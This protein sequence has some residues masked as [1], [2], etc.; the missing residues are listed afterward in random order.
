MTI[1]DWIIKGALYVGTIIFIAAATVW[2]IGGAAG[3]RLGRRF[4]TPTTEVGTWE[5]LTQ[6]DW[7][8]DRPVRIRVSSTLLLEWLNQYGGPADYPSTV[9]VDTEIPEATIRYVYAD[10]QVIDVSVSVLVARDVVPEWSAGP[11]AWASDADVDGHAYAGPPMPEPR[12]RTRYLLADNDHRKYREVTQLRYS[13]CA[14]A[15]GN[16]AAVRAFDGEYYRGRVEEGYDTG[17]GFVLAMGALADGHTDLRQAEI[18]QF[19]GKPWADPNAEVD[20][21]PRRAN[22]ARLAAVHEQHL[23]A[24]PDHDDTIPVSPWDAMPPGFGRIVPAQRVNGSE[25]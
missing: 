21:D 23:G 12:V 10:E 3:T 4:T 18:D 13:Q 14:F 19:N 20:P 24:E 2:A 9:G 7:D 1:T 5:A 16:D 6:P 25:S 11:L 17:E 15:E 22:L 8:A